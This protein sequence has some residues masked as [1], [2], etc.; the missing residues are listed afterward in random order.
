[1]ASSITIEKIDAN[2]IGIG[3]LIKS[4]RFTIPIYQRP[5]SWTDTQIEDLYRDLN[6]AIS[7]TAQDYFLGT[8]VTTR[9]ID[10]GRLTIIDG[11]QRLVTVSIL[12]A[13]IRDHFQSDGQIDRAQDIERE[14][15]FKRDIRTQELTPHIFLTAEDREFFVQT[16]AMG[17]PPPPATRQVTPTSPAQQRL[18]RATE[19]AAAFVASLVQTTQKSDERLLDLID[20]LTEKAKL[21]SVSVGSES[22]AFVIFEVL[23]DRGLDLSITD[24][25]KN[26]IFRTAANRVEEAQAAW[27]QMTT[28]ISEVASEPELKTFIRH[29]WT[30]THGMTRE[31]ELYDAIKK[32][33]N[34]KAKAVEFAKSLSKASTF[35]AGLSNPASDQWDDYQPVVRQSIQVLDQL[36]VSQLRPLVLAI[37]Q[38][39][40]TDEIAKALPAIVAW[41]V[42]FL[43][44]GSGGSGTLETAYAE[45]AKEVSSGKMKTAAALWDAMKAIVPDDITF[46]TKFATATVSKADLAKYYLRILDQ[47]STSANDEMIV[48]PD[49]GKVNLEHILPRNPTEGWTHIPGEQISP[50]IKRLGNLTLLATR[51]NSKAANG[52]FDEK[53]KHF[54]KSAIAMTKGLCALT[55]WTPKEIAVRQDAMADLAVKAWPSKPR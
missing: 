50:L 51:L 2:L 14:Y 26:F 47:Q 17:P 34:S 9:N 24:L 42:R 19:I 52:A 55:D 25:L 33:I 4:S 5:Y 3:S 36:G 41:S 35:Y 46:K 40:V 8:L 1:M 48:N 18:H 6:D 44:C 39:F 28:I 49:Q 45:R 15:L 31:R 29:Y 54:A 16:V 7:G 11:Q 12:I 43:I 21:V 23:N 32:V 37:F 13:S 27:A 10:E 20:F 30:A 53:K 22:S 38:H